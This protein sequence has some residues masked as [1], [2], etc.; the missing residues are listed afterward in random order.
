MHALNAR[1]ASA[2]LGMKHDDCEAKAAGTAPSEDAMLT[3]G[4][5]KTWKIHRQTSKVCTGHQNDAARSGRMVKQKRL[6][7]VFLVVEPSKIIFLIS[8]T[9]LYPKRRI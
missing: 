9:I 5:C 3:V 2:C 1:F 7:S 8:N 6:S 4:D